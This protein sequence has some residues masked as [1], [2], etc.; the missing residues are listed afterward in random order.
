VDETG[1]LPGRGAYLC[2][3]PECWEQGAATLEHA[4]KTRLTADDKAKLTT[5][6]KELVAESSGS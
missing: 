5:R 2:R 3:K 4:L 6:G 1:R